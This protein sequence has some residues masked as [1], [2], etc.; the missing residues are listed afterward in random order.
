M[1]RW[2]NHFYCLNYHLYMQNNL[3]FKFYLL[4]SLSCALSSLYKSHTC[5]PF[6]L[7]LLYLCRT[8]FLQLNQCNFCPLVH[9]TF[10]QSLFLKIQFT[11]VWKNRMVF[12][13]HFT[14]KKWLLIWVPL[15][16]PC[17][18]QTVLLWFWIF[19]NNSIS[20]LS[21]FKPTNKELTV[22]PL[23][24]NLSRNQVGRSTDW[25]TQAPH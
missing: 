25:D 15:S 5:N 6:S 14:V 21:S 2:T 12:I 7:F 4:N 11:T 22:P 19:P 10:L 16:I 24:H 20:L 23:D 1:N 17:K 9:P 18:I 8:L 13:P 3:P